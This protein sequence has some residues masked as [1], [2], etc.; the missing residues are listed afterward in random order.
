MVHGAWCPVPPP[1]SRYPH[2]Q[3]RTVPSTGT[4]HHARTQPST[5]PI[6][7]PSLA[8][9]SLLAVTLL[10]RARDSWPSCTFG[11][12]RSCR[13]RPLCSVALSRLGGYRAH[14]PG[15]SCL[16]RLG[17]YRAPAPRPPCLSRSGGYR[18]PAPRLSCLSRLGGY[19]APRLSFSLSQSLRRVPRAQAGLT[20]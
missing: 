20:I 3:V 12:C 14:R 15:L 2:H 19:R 16:S 9:T 7:R 13:A 18:A 10:K 4:M 8:R 17:G 5:V 11:Y 1:M 6:P